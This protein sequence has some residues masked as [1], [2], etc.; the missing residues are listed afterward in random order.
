MRKPDF[1]GQCRTY[2]A[3]FGLDATDD[4]TWSDRHCQ[5]VKENQQPLLEIAVRDREEI[6]GQFVYNLHCAF[7]QPSKD[8]SRAEWRC[9]HPLAQIRRD[10]HDFVKASV[11][12]EVY[13][14]HF[15]MT[16]FVST[17]QISGI[18]NRLRG[19]CQALVRYINSDVATPAVVA[20]TL[21]FLAAPIT[22]PV[23][24]ALASSCISENGDAKKK[25]SDSAKSQ[26]AQKYVTRIG[27]SSSEGNMETNKD[28]PA[29]R[30][31]E[32]DDSDSED[33]EEGHMSLT[34]AA[35]DI[36]RMRNLKKQTQPFE[37]DVKTEIQKEKANLEAEKDIAIQRAVE[38]ARREMALA[39]EE[40]NAALEEARRQAE[41]EKELAVEQ[42]VASALRERH[43]QEE[44]AEREKALALERELAD[45]RAEMERMQSERALA[46][47]NAAEEDARR[48]GLIASERLESEKD[49]AVEQAVASALREK[50]AQEEIAETTRAEVER[51]E[52]EKVL[53]EKEAALDDARRRAMIESE[54]VES[55]KKLAVEQAVASALRERNAQDQTVERE[56]ALALERALA[57]TRAEM[58]RMQS[59]HARSLEMA[60]KDTLEEVCR[61][62]AEE[63]AKL[64][65]ARRQSLRAGVIP[66]TRENMDLTTNFMDR[67]LAKI[68]D[69]SRKIYD[70]MEKGNHVRRRQAELEMMSLFEV[71]RD[72]MTSLLQRD[73]NGRGLLE[74]VFGGDCCRI[75]CLRTHLEVAQVLK[76]RL[77]SSVDDDDQLLADDPRLPMCLRACESVEKVLQDLG[78]GEA[79]RQALWI[80][81]ES[82]ASHTKLI[83]QEFVATQLLAQEANI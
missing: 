25:T 4:S 38:E 73:V 47:K 67:L 75:S 39:L 31:T 58:E 1:P 57:E 15:G 37:H 68:E 63:A 69:A 74:E 21:K 52:S 72:F 53:A 8:T 19:W 5:L 83:V 51:M 81:K 44:M 56:K 33:D 18:E 20:A 79:L 26:L 41:S 30:A 40:K 34:S 66:V 49:L 70:M 3:Q 29:P 11:G 64:A 62:T 48:Q 46:E 14:K 32:D 24:L 77:A 76:E 82:N 61:K 23:I 7:W 13:A 36:R 54:R 27:P 55:E 45:T 6:A 16:P 35:E 2:L 17:W 78:F 60:R 9:Q 10:L 59:E 42:A 43:A 65:R 80:E 50:S 12:A 22:D 28:V 71:A